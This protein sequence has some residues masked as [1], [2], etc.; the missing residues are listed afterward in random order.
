MGRAKCV[1]ELQYDGTRFCGW[2][3][4]PGEASVHDAV[5]A[6]VRQ[7]TGNAGGVVA[8]GRTDR[9]VHAAHQVVTFRVD[10]RPGA[11]RCAELASAIAAA[12]RPDVRLL[13][14]RGAPKSVHAITA[15]R[16]K[17]GGKRVGTR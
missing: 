5:A 1:L 17:R 13:S 10:E 15:A 8:A 14:C 9:G 4:Q 7:A 2:Q 3:P 16:G 11:E 12:L 6:A